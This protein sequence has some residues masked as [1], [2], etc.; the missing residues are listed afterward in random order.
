MS[1]ATFEKVTVAHETKDALVVM[2]DG[3]KHWVPKSAVDEDSEVY[4][5]D[6]DG[7]FIVAEWW[8]IKAGL[9]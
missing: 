8:A 6:T 7:K 1:T 4:K 5:M 9:V 2:I 3:K